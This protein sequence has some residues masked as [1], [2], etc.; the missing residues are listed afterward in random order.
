MREA[1]WL[2]NTVT[3]EDS[4]KVQLKPARWRVRP[5]AGRLRV[6]LRLRLV[7]LDHPVILGCS[8]TAAHHSLSA[9]IH[10]NFAYLGK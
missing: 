8:T 10:A 4:L 5:D 3:F 9:C 6:Q 7:G 2:L 1:E